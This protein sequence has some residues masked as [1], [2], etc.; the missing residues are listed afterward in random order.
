[1]HKCECESILKN[2]DMRWQ[3]QQQ[4]LLDINMKMANFYGATRDLLTIID[5]L[6]IKKKKKKTKRS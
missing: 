2:L 1:M 3:L 5:H 4:M 6:T